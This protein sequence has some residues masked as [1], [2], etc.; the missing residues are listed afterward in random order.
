VSIN[1][2]VI[3]SEVAGCKYLFNV[4]GELF[5]QPFSAS[6]WEDFC[7]LGLPVEKVPEIINILRKPLA[8]NFSIVGQTFASY[9]VRAIDFSRTVITEILN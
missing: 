9:T 7:P 5:G 6:S 1:L 8:G 2:V 4:G 3:N